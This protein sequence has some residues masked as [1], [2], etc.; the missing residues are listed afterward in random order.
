MYNLHCD[1]FIQVQ[2]DKIDS[3]HRKHLRILFRIFY[4][5]IITNT[6]LYYI[7]QQI[8]ISILLVKRRWNLLGHLFRQNENAPF[9]LMMSHYYYMGDHKKDYESDRKRCRTSIPE[10]INRELKLLSDNTWN[11]LY[12]TIP[13]DDN[14]FNIIPK[15]ELLTTYSY[16]Y[17]QF[18]A[19][20]RTIWRN[21]TKDI[22][23]HITNLYFNTLTVRR[24]K[25]RLRLNNNLQGFQH[26]IIINNDDNQI[27]HNN[28]NNNNNNLLI[29]NILE[30]LFPIEIVA[31]EDAI[32]LNNQWII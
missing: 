10:L 5:Q 12:N 20:D 1:A 4:P 17:L 25:R 26:E 31:G 19:Q 6:R 32:D 29:N 30:Q 15:K 16:R 13:I 8:P 7:S 23:S 18:I 2:L 21:I 27:H 14:I 3:I 9:N 11:H 22:V 28:N 24:D